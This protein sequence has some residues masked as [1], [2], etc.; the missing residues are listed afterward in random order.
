MFLT[1]QLQIKAILQRIEQTSETPLHAIVI[2]A[3]NIYRFDATAAQVKLVYSIH[4]EKIL[5]I[6]KFGS[7]I[8]RQRSSNLFCEIART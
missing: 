6:I 1:R 2:D 3:R 4:S 8:Y 7:G 5:D